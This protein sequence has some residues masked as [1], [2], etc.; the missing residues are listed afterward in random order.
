M[1]NHNGSVGVTTNTIYVWAIMPCW[2]R[3]PVLPQTS[4]PNSL[5]LGQ[6]RTG[7]LHGM[8][9][10]QNPKALALPVL[11]HCFWER[12]DLHFICHCFGNYFCLTQQDNTQGDNTHGR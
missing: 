10:Y 7:A 9:V 2:C 8:K 12:V 1:V 6:G 11:F 4:N 5:P 3:R